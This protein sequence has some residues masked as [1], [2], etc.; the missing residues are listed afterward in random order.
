MKHIKPF[1]IIIIVLAFIPFHSY[2][3]SYESP[4]EYMQKI[5]DALDN[6]KRDTW[7]YLKAVTRGKR[8]RKIERKRENLIDE[9]YASKNQIRKM[10]KYETRD[11]LRIAAIDYL[12]MSY[13]VLKEDYDKILD[14]EDIAEQ[15]YDMMEAYLLAKEKASE[16]LNQSFEDLVYAQEKF[17]E[18]HDVTLQEGEQDRM[19]RKISDAGETL[20]YYNDVYLI[21]FKAYK[22]EAYVMEALDKNDI[23]S[24]EQ[25]TASLK[26]FS[27][28][29]IEDLKKM[30][31]FQ[32]DASLKNGAIKI[33]RFYIKEAEGDF[34]TMT[35]Y[36]IKK[37]NFEKIK[38][39]FDAKKKR[40]RTKQDI[41]QFNKAVNEYNASAKKA[42]KI[43][44]SGN[45]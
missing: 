20:S 17:A 31:S 29:G 30:D 41:K 26:Q 34:A 23:M 13:T 39:S 6:T 28:E 35:D 45:K 21:F 3:Q 18:K 44:N 32:G 9:I 14:M 43:L 40:N 24:F 33:L 19:S 15:S 10:P 42:N 36:F 1:I 22:E 27:E 38:K 7:K 37:D 4:V 11:S 2:A 25:S 5:S 8:A 12:D 16:K